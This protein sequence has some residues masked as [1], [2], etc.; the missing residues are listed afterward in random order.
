MW[1]T[2]L[3]LLLTPTGRHVSKDSASGQLHDYCVEFEATN[4]PLVSYSNVP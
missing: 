2:E 4:G 3:Y 1:E